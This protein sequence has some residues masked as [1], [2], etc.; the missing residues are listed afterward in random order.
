MRRRREIQAI[1]SFSKKRKRPS[2][3]TR[4]NLAAENRFAFPSNWV[5]DSTYQGRIQLL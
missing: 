3:G 1:F 5:V 2:A 4:T